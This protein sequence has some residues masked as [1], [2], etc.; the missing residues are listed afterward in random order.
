M[1]SRKSKR[2][3]S[4]FGKSSSVSNLVVVAID[5][6]LYG[7]ISRCFE[8]G[9]GKFRWDGSARSLNNPVAACAVLR[10]RPGCGM[11]RFWRR[12]CRFSPVIAWYNNQPCDPALFQDRPARFDQPSQLKRRQIH[13]SSC[14]PVVL[15]AFRSF[16]RLL[17]AM[18]LTSTPLRTVL[19][20]VIAV[21]TVG[22][23]RSAFNA[24]GDGD[25]IVLAPGTYQGSF[26]VSGLTGVTIRSADPTNP[27]VIVQPA[28]PTGSSS[29]APCV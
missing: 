1:P 7:H 11:N 6:P 19:G 16:T 12:P 2:C 26:F 15:L 3:V 28:E 25:E 18:L 14:R 22:E 27:A 29:S 5:R 8:I 23:R 9:S 13:A 20:G 24:A 10:N 17:C 4:R 21:D